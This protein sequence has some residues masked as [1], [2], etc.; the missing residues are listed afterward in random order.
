MVR[1]L[2]WMNGSNDVEITSLPGGRVD[3]TLD[4]SFEALNLFQNRKPLSFIISHQSFSETR[5]T[6]K[7][8]S[9]E[10]KLVFSKGYVE[11]TLSRP[12]VD[13]MLNELNLTE[14]MRRIEM[15]GFG[16]DEIMIPTLDAADAIAAPG[17]FTHHCFAKNVEV[18]HITR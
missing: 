13:F 8:N 7:F 4:W 12:M 6:M 14:L 17:G 16:V 3:E 2:K 15:K 5:N 9:Y 18:K 11:S 1:I 10:P